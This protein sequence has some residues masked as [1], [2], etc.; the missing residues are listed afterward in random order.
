M[1]DRWKKEEERKAVKKEIVFKTE[2]KP[3]VDPQIKLPSKVADTPIKNP[4]SGEKIMTK[5]ALPKPP[6]TL[7]M[8]SKEDR[9]K[10]LEKTQQEREKKA[11]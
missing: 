8:A 11:L 9:I 3:K 1:Q 6:P 2:E 7:N 10:E 4:E 5:S